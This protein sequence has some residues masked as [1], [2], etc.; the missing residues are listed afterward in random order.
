M[1]G[2]QTMSLAH[3]EWQPRVNPWIIA[4]S[5]MLATFMEV[6]DTS[7]ASVA[8]PHIAGN[9]GATQDEATWV[10]TSY[11][12]SN[13]IV[14]PASTWFSGFFG[15]KRFLTGCIV[16]FT[17]S[18]FI[19]G[20]A[21]SLGML[22]LARVVQGAG[23]GALQPLAQSIVMESFPPARRGVAMAVYGVGVICAPIIGP[24][25]G[26]WLTDT[27]SWRW[28]FYINIPVGIVAV[29]M[30]STFVEDPPY[31]RGN[32]RGRMDVI[33]FGLMSL[34]LSTMQIILDKG[35]QADWFGAVWLRWFAGIS[36][37]S[38]IG[39]I[40]WELRTPSPVVDLRILKN[41][42]FAIGCALF[43]MFGAAIYGLIAL[44]PLFLQSLMGY[45]ALD[46]G[47]TVSPRGLGALAAMFLVG[48]LVQRTNPRYL[49]AFGFG[50]FAL[51]SLLLSRLT[52]DVSMRE[53]VTPNVLNGFG[54]GFIFVPLG[55]VTLGVLRNDQ[56][57][58]AAG[59]Q[60]LVRNVGG[61]IGISF[62]STML[63]RYAQAHQVFLAG[64]I[65]P[66]SP[67]YHAHVTALQGVFAAHFSAPDALQRAQAMIYNSV[68]QQASY[69]AFVQLFYNIMWMCVACMVGVMLLR[70][71]KGA[72][73][74]AG[75]H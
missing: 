44:Q 35:Q 55:T 68:L 58:N 5:V 29:M 11:L 25:F 7:I 21:T 61:S 31:I 10:L 72:R 51:S 48:I 60:N 71:V 14:L 24:T 74:V 75:A 2:E 37:A 50:M 39:F 20:A 38:F 52:L 6:L 65:S 26:G 53:I 17:V 73:P 23:G 15:R 28:A 1:S 22:V 46:A 13:A 45:T 57:G 63:V 66:L 49:L 47:L 56:I 34:W 67:A 69:W 33:G 41:W 64:R 59:I 8:L 9:L 27:Y 30:I 19:C 3:V 16:I 18:S 40:I 62:I 70:T 12:V 42:N 4:L 32:R 43:G 54:S 36:V